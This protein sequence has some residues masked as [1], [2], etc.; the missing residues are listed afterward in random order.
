LRREIYLIDQPSD[1]NPNLDMAVADAVAT[2]DAFLNEGKT[3]LVHC[4]GGRSRTGLIL[5]AWKMKREGWSGAA[6]EQKAHDWLTNKWPLYANTHFKEF[7]LKY[8]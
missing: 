3:V 2:I 1:A 6:G 4:H 8:S 7:L 5:K